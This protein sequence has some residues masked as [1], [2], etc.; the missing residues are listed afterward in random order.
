MNNL[1]TLSRIHYFY[2]IETITPI[3]TTPHFH[4]T[5]STQAPSIPGILVLLSTTLVVLNDV[6][7]AHTFEAKT[8]HKLGLPGPLCQVMYISRVLFSIF[9]LL[10]NLLVAILLLSVCRTHTIGK[11]LMYRL[12]CIRWLMPLASQYLLLILYNVQA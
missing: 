3:F 9:A 7:S 2:I 10:W 6:S 12:Y 1:D 5:T 11:N 4:I 8:C